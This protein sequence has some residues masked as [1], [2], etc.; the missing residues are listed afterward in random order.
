ME[1]F[2]LPDN[3]CTTVAKVFRRKIICRFGTL[4]A[5]WS[6]RG[7]EFAGDFMNYCARLGIKHW[8]VLPQNPNA[9]G[10]VE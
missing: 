6:D 2:V 8:I 5:I 1:A 9:N 3:H 7:G 10:I 4:V